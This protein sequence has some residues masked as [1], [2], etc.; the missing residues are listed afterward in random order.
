MGGIS[1]EACSLAG[2]LGLG[3]LTVFYD[4]IGISIDGH[5]AG[6]FTD[7][8][9]LRFAAYGWHV[10]AAI[11][12]H[13]VGAVDAAIKAAHAVTDRPSLLCCKTT[14]GRGAPTKAGTEAAHGAAL[15]EKEVAATRA[16]LGW[17]YPPFEMPAAIY[18]TS[19]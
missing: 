1:H 18:A 3:K 16:A 7:D 9:P 15:G 2:T 8:T 11:D 12:G 6:W 13:D 10:I 5:V 17:T 14:I 19:D 4:D